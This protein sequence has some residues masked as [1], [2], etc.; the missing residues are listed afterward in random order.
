MVRNFLDGRMVR[1]CENC[2]G[3]FY[4]SIS[5]CM[6]AHHE[7]LLK[8]GFL[9]HPVLPKAQRLSL[10]SGAVAAWR[11]SA[12]SLPTAGAGCTG[13]RQAGC[14]TLQTEFLLKKPW[15]NAL[16]FS[17]VWSFSCT[18]DLFIIFLFASLFFLPCQCATGNGFPVEINAFVFCFSCYP[19]P[20]LFHHGGFCADTEKMT[21]LGCTNNTC[22]NVATCVCFWV[23]F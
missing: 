17:L 15:F 3:K 5:G 13:Q 12:G 23:F 21:S 16:V 8:P 22:N 4:G 20:L 10:G 2:L 7:H 11:Q 14:F 9:V 6:W 18:F 19:A 1:H